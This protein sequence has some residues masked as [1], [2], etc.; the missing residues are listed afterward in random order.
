M[1]S[2]MG[3]LFHVILNGAAGGVKDLRYDNLHEMCPPDSSRTLR[4]T[5]RTLRMTGRTLRMT[6]RTLRMTEA[7]HVRMEDA[8][9][10]IY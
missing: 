2:R 4:M 10:N 9:Q 1:S 3:L 8:T 6:G 5:G 7:R